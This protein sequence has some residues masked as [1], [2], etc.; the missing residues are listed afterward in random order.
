MIKQFKFE[1]V[2]YKLEAKEYF[3][4]DNQSQ[5]IWDQHW[6]SCELAHYENSLISVFL[7]LVASINKNFVLSG[8]LGTRR[9]WQ[10]VRQLI[11]TMFISNNRASLH[12]W[13]KENLV[14]HQKL[15]KYF[16]IDFFQIFTFLLMSLLRALIV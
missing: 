12:L 4:R 15:S 7:E 5:N 6:F 11:Y 13:W 2:W 3:S 8:S 9:F 14:K 1:G 10:L 16:E